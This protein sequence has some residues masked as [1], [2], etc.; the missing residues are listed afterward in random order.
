MKIASRRRVKV[1]LWI[2]LAAA[3]V[4]VT[5]GTIFAAGEQLQ[6]SSV[7]SGGGTTTAGGLSLMATMGLPVAGS[8]VTPSGAGLCSGFGC[9]SRSD[10]GPEEPSDDLKLFMPSVDKAQ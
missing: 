3:L 9:N 4:I 5:T 10:S 2:L 7:V 6:R 1:A 8:D